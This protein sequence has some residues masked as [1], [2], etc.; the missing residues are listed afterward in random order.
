M[1][2]EIKTKK[3][4]WNDYKEKIKQGKF[5]LDNLLKDLNGNCDYT[6][7]I[8]KL[9]NKFVDKNIERMF[10]GRDRDIK[11]KKEMNSD[12]VILAQDQTNPFFSAYRTLNITKGKNFYN[13]PVLL[14]FS[15]FKSW[16]FHHML[17]I[18][19]NL[20]LITKDKNA[21]QEDFDYQINKNLLSLWRNKNLNVYSNNDAYIEY[22]RFLIPNGEIKKSLNEIIELLY[23]MFILNNPSKLIKLLNKS[24]KLNEEISNENFILSIMNL[25]TYS[26]R[27]L[28]Y[29]DIIDDILFKC[30]HKINYDFKLFFSLQGILITLNTFLQLAED[31]DNVNLYNIL[32]KEFVCEFKILNNKE[33]YLNFVIETLQNFFEFDDMAKESTRSTSNDLLFIFCSIFNVK[34]FY[35]CF[36]VLVTKNGVKKPRLR[37]K[38]IYPA[39][40]LMNK[41][42]ENIVKSVNIKVILYINLEIGNLYYL[43]NDQEILNFNLHQRF[44]NVL[45]FPPTLQKNIVNVTLL[46][47]LEYNINIL[48]LI[49][50]YSENKIFEENKNYTFAQNEKNADYIS[51]IQNL[52][53]LNSDVNNFCSEIIPILCNEDEIQIIKCKLDSYQ[54]YDHEQIANL[55]NPLVCEEMSEIEVFQT[56][57]SECLNNEEKTYIGK[58]ETI[59]NKNVNK[60]KNFQNNIEFENKTKN[61]YLE[62][63][64]LVNQG[65]NEINYMNINSNLANNPNVPNNISNNSIRFNNN[66]S[67]DNKFGN[68]NL[69][70][71]YLK[72]PEKTVI[73]TNLNEKNKMPNNLQPNYINLDNKNNQ[74]INNA[75]FNNQGFNNQNNNYNQ[76]QNRVIIP[77]SN[78]NVRQINFQQLKNDNQNNNKGIQKGVQNDIKKSIMFNQISNN[79]QNYNNVN[80]LSGNRQILK[81]NVTNSVNNRSSLINPNI[82]YLFV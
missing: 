33:D 11:L 31:V 7:P 62:P 52:D 40:E 34:L 63:Q 78:L 55:F 60:V 79:N 20:D 14:F 10:M 13:S 44:K 24:Y 68:N 50:N 26:E 77:N 64:K 9:I 17:T 49:Q 61:Y 18:S 39:F 30:D 25:K 51:V 37:T 71:N 16:F 35:S 67:F 28:R 4:V 23:E 74:N 1:E 5:D 59:I 6:S 43:Y 65:I 66:S 46:D 73:I 22:D 82:K 42:K 2:E 32:N 53:N 80:Q 70:K 81:S 54:N 58:N 36:P 41:C 38:K 15:V 47:I 21:N 76:I 3:N 12:E 29:L 19:K 8:Y 69:K 72:A 27:F 48:G 57:F 56:Y 45:L 75:Q